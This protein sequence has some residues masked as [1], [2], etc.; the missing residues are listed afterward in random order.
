MTSATEISSELR[1][2]ADPAQA[3]VLQRFFKTGK[4][5]YGEGDIFLGVKVPHIRAVAKAN[6][7]AAE[8]ADCDLLTKS[9]Y[10]EERLAGF[11]LLI[12]LYKRSL[13][14]RQTGYDPRRIVEYYISVLERGNNWDLVDLVAPKILGDWL[15]RNPE[16][17][18]ILMQLASS[19]NLWKERV[20]VVS[21]MP[22]IK[23]GDFS[24]TFDLA[25]MFAAHPHDLINKATG[26]MLREVGKVNLK[27]LQNFLD[28][29]CTEITR[30]TLSYAT[31]HLEE[32]RRISYRMQLN[33]AIKM[34]QTGKQP[35]HIPMS[36]RV[37]SIKAT[38]KKN[39]VPKK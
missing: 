32:R 29:H 12:E 38:P 18:G 4:G 30:T 14:K 31:E 8:L 2:A 22:R 9:V 6:S 23:N 15:L 24:L 26:W 19:R 33:E 1:R 10:H 17:E 35:E 7:K 11:L 27:S 28:R 37:S 21:T 3:S 39:A 34:R 20:A 25:L 36:H 16:S 5:E 13:K